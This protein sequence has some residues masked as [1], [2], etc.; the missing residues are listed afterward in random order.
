MLFCFDVACHHFRAGPKQGCK[1]Q[2]GGGRTVY[3]C[4]VRLSMFHVIWLRYI[5]I[6]F[7]RVKSHWCCFCTFLTSS[8]LHLFLRLLSFFLKYLLT[9][10]QL[11]IFSSSHLLMCTF[12]LTA[13]DFHK[14]YSHR[15]I[16]TASHLHTFLTSS[17]LLIVTFSH[18]QIFSSSHF[19]HIFTSS[20]PCLS[21]PL[22]LLLSCPLALLPPGTL[23]TFAFLLV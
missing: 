23:A 2:L 13:S 4:Y 20:L 9:A 22:A 17:H 15:L 6:H 7:H 21:C 5:L 11:H 10:S 16:V 14:F 1:S 8:C 18:F 19:L 12:F 3:R